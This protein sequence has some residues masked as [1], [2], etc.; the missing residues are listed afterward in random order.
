M[1]EGPLTGV[2]VLDLSLNLP[3]PYAT[4]ILLSLGASVIK[5]EPPKGDPARH[6]GE[7]FARVNRGKKSVVLDLRDPAG[8]DA[9]RA[10]AAQTDVVVEGF[11]PGVMSLCRPKPRWR[12]TRASCGVRSAPSARRGP[13]PSTR[14]TT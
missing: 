11:R 4:A 7:L 2:E 10:L 5:V 9:L 6:I 3:G 13:A 12:R 8:Q 1:A 14:R